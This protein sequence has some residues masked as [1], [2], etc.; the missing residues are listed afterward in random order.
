[1]VELAYQHLPSEG[2]FDAISETNKC[3]PDS[4]QLLTPCTI[5]NGWLRIIDIGRYALTLYN[6]KQGE[7]IR[8]FV[9]TA[10]LDKCPEIKSWILKF[11]N[12]KEQDSNLLLQEILKAETNILS[13]QKVK[14][15]MSL[16]KKR[17]SSISIC[18]VCGEGYHSADG[19]MCLSCRGER[20]YYKLL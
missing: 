20:Q 9:D 5:G 1:M 12:K 15:D 11:K 17:M 10:K 16:L 7:G 2:L 19:E 14:M 3:L 6:K 8:V 18:P 4:I 13:Y